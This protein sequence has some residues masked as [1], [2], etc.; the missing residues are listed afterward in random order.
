MD[1]LIFKS[2]DLKRKIGFFQ[3]LLTA[4]LL[5][6]FLPL[7][8]IRYSPLLLISFFAVLL[9]RFKPVPLRKYSYL[10]LTNAITI[11]LYFLYGPANAAFWI[12]IFLI[13]ADR[14]FKKSLF[15]AMING[16]AYALSIFI[17]GIIFRANI[18]DN[19]VT[20]LLFFLIHFILVVGIFY[21]PEFISRK[22]KLN[23]I[24]FI[25]PWEVFYYILYAIAAYTAFIVTSK[26]NP[27][28]ISL[29]IIGFLIIRWFIRKITSDAVEG[30]IYRDLI[31]LQSEVIK[32]S[33]DET[34]RAVSINSTRY[35]DWTGLNIFKVDYDREEIA[36]IYSTN[37]EIEKGSAIPISSG[38]TGKCVREEKPIIVRNIRYAE[39][40]IELKS[41]VKSE[42]ALPLISDY[43]VLGVI[44]FEH[45]LIGA[46]TEKE[47]EY[48]QFFASLLTYALQ[49]HISLQ[50]LVNTSEKL[51]G[52]TEET[53]NT[54]NE[55]REE[56]DTI[57]DK[58]KD[59][60][61]GGNSQIRALGEVEKALEEL[62]VSHE[63]IKTLREEII[64]RVK[65]FNNILIR[66]R[67]SV[68]DN[69][70]LLNE[71]TETTRA[72]EGTIKPLTTLSSNV[73]E[74]ANSS[75][76]IAEDTSILA[77]N[78]SIEAE[79]A[80]ELGGAFS[81]IAEE[82]NELA[83][84]ASSNTD[85]ISKIAKTILSDVKDLTN[86]TS[87]VF[88]ATKNIEFASSSIMEQFDRIGTQMSS[89]QEGLD[90]TIEVSKCEI[91]YIETLGK[92]IE[93]SSVI[94]KDNIN[95]IKNINELIENQRQVIGNLNEK[96][97]TIKD[98]MEKLGTI[99]EEFRLTYETGSSS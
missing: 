6:I 91:D 78:A 24:L 72:V 52:F 4:V 19:L 50:P 55:I 79:R 85:E 71:I 35:V 39:D 28:N 67:D 31:K 86:R 36:L 13:I 33:F 53:Y 68:L 96:V 83:K 49:T 95:F 70:K 7:S 32:R 5:G 77:L 76:E 14:I 20:T 18:M 99:V 98:S 82:M 42:M 25:I 10:S 46:F 74:I 81:I 58:M 40:Y 75:K 69:I 51:K 63:N 30:S 56:I 23:E 60:I 93:R 22:S 34:V 87:K 94:G 41:D 90:L 27:L 84:T 80:G 89:I 65:E 73:M 43:N 64:G 1:I 2:L 59:I 21:S 92:R 48:A 17:A 16:S 47:I 45:N 62:L 97:I 57:Q 26:P 54:T 61:S 37:K 15:Q 11:L 38:I 44:D 3:I 88:E 9:F 66:S 12:F 29:F 8:G